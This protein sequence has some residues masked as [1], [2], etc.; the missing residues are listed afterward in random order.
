MHSLS[1][2]AIVVAHKQPD[3]LAETLKALKAQTLSPSQIML[4]ETASDPDSLQIARDLG[5]PHITPGSL[6]LG[7]A[8]NA[9]L[10]ALNESTGWIWILHE[11]SKP[12]PDALERL[13]I[14]AETS[15]SVGIIG[16]KLLQWDDPIRIQ[17]L[18]LTMTRTGRPFLV[19]KDEY[20]Q[21][22]HDTH[23]DTLAVS[24]AAMLISR[25]L[26][27]KLDGLDDQTPVFAQDLE[28]GLRARALGYRV[29]VES[30]AKV[31]HAGLSMRSERPR[32]WV[33]GSVVQG[34]SKAHVHLAT[35]LLP[36][37]WLFLLYLAMPA[38]V[39]LSIPLNLWAKRPTRTIGQLTSWLWSWRTL[40]ARLR[41]RKKTRA[42]GS[43]KTAKP[44]F[45]SSLQVRRRKTDQLEEPEQIAGFSG[46]FGS[47]QA[48]F[49][50][51]PALVSLRLWPSGAIYSENLVPMAASLAEVWESVSVT[52]LLSGYGLLAP[53]DP[54]NWF[55]ALVAAL[56]PFGPSQGL[57]I[58]VF[59][60]GPIAFFTSW[61]LASIFVAKPWLRTVVAL[62]YVLSPWFFTSSYNADVVE[63]TAMVFAP[64]AGFF[65]AKALV[66]FNTARSWRWTGLAGLAMAIVAV[67]SPTLFAILTIGLVA[68]GFYFYRRIAI[69]IWALLPGAVL[70][71]PWVSFW[72]DTNPLLIL[73]TSSAA[74]DPISLQPDLQ[75]G[76]LLL[77]VF[78]SLIGIFKTRWPRLLLIAGLAIL[79]LASLA[80]QPFTSQAASLQFGLLLLL[81]LAATGLDQARKSVL[82]GT[83]MLALGLVIANAVLITISTQ[84]NFRHG[85]DRQL[86][87]LIVAQS[88]V[89]Q[90]GVLTLRI[91]A[92]QDAAVG[93]LI[94]GSGVTLEKRGLATS[95]IRADYDRSMIQQLVAA[96]IAGNPES[97]PGLISKTGV[98]FILLSSE[99]PVLQGRL[100]VGISAME[101]LQPAGQSEYGLLWRTTAVTPK[102]VV[103]IDPIRTLQLAVIAGFGLLALPTPAAIRGTRKARSRR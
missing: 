14:A 63:L 56:S 27:Q 75:A 37:P 95:F 101:F 91:D 84:P 5:V 99:D 90:S 97:V 67:S 22:Q 10:A 49:A 79:S 53:S 62:G 23:G 100:E 38:I 41:A 17:Q 42:F 34:L 87:A 55:L 83:S 102:P 11:D 36:W 18:G 80:L 47:N 2:A 32:T 26:W 73:S 9:G 93:E 103:P 12:E 21:G 92:S 60:A 19:V 96:L 51:L 85:P 30:S 77:A 86:P 28:I 94:W 16:P 72:F 68:G 82:V 29:M 57:A 98:S 71:W 50:L 7:A 88:Q 15:P 33:K 46:V 58:F 31:L 64:L 69:A 3:Y 76:Y 52:K 6:G 74:A 35:T 48:W 4:V 70:V 24:T 1:V 65:L 43:L 78:L 61:Q 13:S 44:L 66:A 54:Y 59:L 89:P 20:D 81:V 39:V 40:P 45:A 25:D 8:I